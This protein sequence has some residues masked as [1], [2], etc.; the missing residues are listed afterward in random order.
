MYFLDGSNPPEN[1]LQKFI[2]KCEETTGGIGK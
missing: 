2:A 1:I